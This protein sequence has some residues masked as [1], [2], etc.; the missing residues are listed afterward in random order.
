MHSQQPYGIHFP[1]TLTSD[2][3]TVYFDLTAQRRTFFS[4]F[5]PYAKWRQFLFSQ[6]TLAKSLLT[7]F[8]TAQPLFLRL[9][10]LSLIYYHQ[11]QERLETIVQDILHNDELLLNDKPILKFAQHIPMSDIISF[12]DVSVEHSEKRSQNQNAAQRRW[13]VFLLW[14]VVMV[15]LP[16]LFIATIGIPIAVISLVVR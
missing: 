8:L 13:S 10:N 11:R 4:L 5:E 14:T 15:T 16:Y 7:Q 6:H 2:L 1:A 12:C 9:I 3:D